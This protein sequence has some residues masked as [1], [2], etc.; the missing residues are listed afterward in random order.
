MADDSLF[1]DF[2][3][4]RGQ[5]LYRYGYLLTGNHHDADDLV[6]DAL[7]KLRSHW[8]QVSRKDDPTGYVRTTMARAHVSVWRRR[9]R[10]V[11]TAL[12][13]DHAVDDPGIDRAEHTGRAGRIW[14]ALAQLPPRQRTVLV[15]RY[16]EHLTDAEI[17]ASLNVRP[18]TVRSNVSRG[19]EKLRAAGIAALEEVRS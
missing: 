14:V 9:R 8:S 5:A 12:P 13:L 3:R 6:Q 7:I 1:A 15:L 11:L 17:A 2:V 10:E 19:L 18:V 4:M 16:Y